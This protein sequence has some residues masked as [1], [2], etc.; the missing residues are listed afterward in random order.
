MK[1]KSYIV[2]GL[3]TF[4]KNVVRSLA[5]SSIELLV[6]DQDA[7]KLE[8]VADI[9]LNRVC[10]DMADPITLTQLDTAGFDGAIIDTGNNF[11]SKVLITMQLKERGVP[12]II[13]KASSEIESR[14]LHQVGADKVIQP[15]REMGVRIAKQIMGGKYFEAIEMP[16]NYSTEDF[17]VPK[18]WFEN[19]I[20][21]LEIRTKYGVTVLGIYRDNEFLVNPSPNL[22]LQSGDIALLL[23]EIDQM[24][25]LRDS[26]S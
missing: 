8:E 16:Q 13:V 20:R 3:S 11:E 6:I 19:S 17:V 4:G 1:K 18:D 7:K 2:I 14:V 26:F 22:V 24:K 9:V 23:G 12:N 5:L 10:A 25:L 21:E 15:D